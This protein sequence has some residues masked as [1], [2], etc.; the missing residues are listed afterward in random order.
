MNIFLLGN[1]FDLHYNLPTSY[2]NFIN[3]VDYLCKHQTDPIRNVG[4]V[5]RPIAE[6]GEDRM[7]CESYKTFKHYYKEV[8]LLLEERTD[9]VNIAENNAWFKYFIARKVKGNGWIDFEKEIERVLELMEIIFSAAYYPSDSDNN[10]EGGAVPVKNQS[11]IRL[12]LKSFELGDF[13]STEFIP[14]DYESCYYLTFDSETDYM[15]YFRKD[16]HIYLSSPA[17]PELNTEAIVT[18]LLDSLHEFSKLLSLYLDLFIQKPLTMIAT[19]KAVQLDK[20]FRF[21]DTV[22]SLNYTNTFETLYMENNRAEIHHI[23]GTVGSEIVL[24]VS[25]NETDELSQ[26]NVRYQGF[27]KYFQR[28]VYETDSS[29]L[30]LI[31]KLQLQKYSQPDRHTYLYVFGHS[32]DITDR[33]IITELFKISDEIIIY[34]YNKRELA[35][36]VQRLTTIYGKKE[37]DSLRI[38]KGLSFYSTELL[39]DN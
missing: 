36:Y 34:Y 17:L 33:D 38:S 12:I 32:L 27:K 21:P 30:H 39:N 2:H 6:S 22:I 37:F 4:D 35:N 18:E 8:A 24:G 5:F 15:F 3:T 31:Q 14:T 7:I 25:A 26:L 1:G 10:F 16:L 28:V 19:K 9:I 23:H 29:Y 13:D 20:I 11:D